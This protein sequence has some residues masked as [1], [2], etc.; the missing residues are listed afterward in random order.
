M[1]AMP[2]RLARKRR[3]HRCRKRPPFFRPVPLRARADGWDEARQC[4]FLAALYVIG[5]VAAAAR[6]VGMSR[7]SA[8]RLRERA[9]AESFARAWDRV[10]TPPGSGHVPAPKEDFRKVTLRELNRRLKTEL[11]QPVI[12]RGRMT[13]IR[14]KPDNSA[15]FRLLRRTGGSRDPH[16][17]GD[18]GW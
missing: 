3:A 5:S 2:K 10:L 6:A 1:L 11:V 9:G 7:A 16:P 14:R 18:A 15:L 8:Y 17:E 13:A 12:Y 4:G